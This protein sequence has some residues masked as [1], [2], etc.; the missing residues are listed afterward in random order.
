MGWAGS[1]KG[2]IIHV[3]VRAHRSQGVERLSEGAGQEEG[4]WVL[5][6]STTTYQL[7]HMTVITRFSWDEVSIQEA[8]IGYLL[9]SMDLFQVSEK[10]PSSHTLL[11]RKKKHKNHLYV[12]LVGI[13]HVI[14]ETRLLSQ[15]PDF[16]H[17]LW[18]HTLWKCITGTLTG[19]SNVMDL[20]LESCRC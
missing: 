20:L 19:C 11:G 15:N 12:Q 16:F 5:R 13:K 14:F 17:H 2:P 6:P 8:A 1:W 10:N 4:P 18:V 7:Y 3:C 9:D